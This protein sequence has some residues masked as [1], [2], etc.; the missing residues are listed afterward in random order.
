MIAQERTD[1]SKRTPRM[2]LATPLV[3]SRSVSG[4]AARMNARPEIISPSGPKFIDQIY[5][6]TRSPGIQTVQDRTSRFLLA[7]S[8]HLYPISGIKPT[9]LRGEH[10]SLSIKGPQIG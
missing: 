7:T 6:S 8:T 2:T 9:R 5:R 4:L 10:R 1:R 3:C